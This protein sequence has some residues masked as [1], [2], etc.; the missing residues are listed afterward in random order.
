M[1]IAAIASSFR[2][3]CYVDAAGL[4]AC[5]LITAGAYLL[6]VRPI[7][8][9][10]TAQQARLAELDEARAQVAALNASGR[11]LRAQIGGLESR[12][13]VNEITLQPASMVNQRLAR[14]T[15]LAGE[16]GLEV[17]Y[18]QTGAHQFGPRYGQVPILVSCTGSYRTCATFLHR[19]RL[20][21]PDT[22]VRSFQMSASPG[23]V[24]SPMSF[25][26][27]LSW[28]VLPRK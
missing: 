18:V 27:Q 25:G 17:Q 23:D 1:N 28:Y 3:A 20:E 15:A 26:L 7:L 4:A 6:A 5:A 19:A 8:D 10:R 12:L 22:A 13:A 11:R 9:G 24:T 21:F 2:R 14:V 16:C